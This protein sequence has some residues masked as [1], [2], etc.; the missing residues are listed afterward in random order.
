MEEDQ[1]QEEEENTQEEEEEEEEIY[2]C[3]I[4][5]KDFTYYAYYEHRYYCNPGTIKE[6]IYIYKSKLPADFDYENNPETFSCVICNSEFASDA[7]Y[8]EHREKCNVGNLHDK[9][10]IFISDDERE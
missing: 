9:E 1:D 7:K 8:D 2:E 3:S 10:F 4:C 6:K 5:N